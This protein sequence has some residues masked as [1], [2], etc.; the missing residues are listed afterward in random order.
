MIADSRILTDPSLGRRVYVI[1]LNDAFTED[2]YR[3]VQ[4]TLYNRTRR[5]ASFTYRV[6]WFDKEGMLIKS[7]MSNRT[8][9]QIEGGQQ[10]SIP[11][12][13]TSPNA[14]DFRCTILESK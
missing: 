11:V 5:M 13:A 2:G 9:Y 1:G 7:P 10:L 8:A 14:V 3:K 12:V 4:I 6:E